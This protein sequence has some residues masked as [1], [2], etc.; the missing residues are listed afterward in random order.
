MSK[1]SWENPETGMT[2]TI[3]LVKTY[4]SKGRDCH[5]IK[6]HA[7]K[8]EQSVADKQFNLCQDTQNNWILEE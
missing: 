5:I 4:S 3:T 6:N 7:L 1:V 8:Y 2:G